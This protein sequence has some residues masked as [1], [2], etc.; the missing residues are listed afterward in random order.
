MWSIFLLFSA[1]AVSGGGD[2]EGLVFPFDLTTCS[3][4][5]DSSECMGLLLLEVC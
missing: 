2:R 1:A 4:S 3:S 5:A